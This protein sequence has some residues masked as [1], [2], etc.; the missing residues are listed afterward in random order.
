[1][2]VYEDPQATWEKAFFSR[3]YAYRDFHSAATGAVPATYV[4]GTNTRAISKWNWP[5]AGDIPPG[6][7]PGGRRMPCYA[8][9]VKV[10]CT[11][12]AWIV[13]TSINPDYVR[14]VEMDYTAEQI[15]AYGIP[16]YLVEVPQYL[17]ADE[18]IT[19]YPKYAVSVAWYMATVPGVIYVWCEGNVEGG[20]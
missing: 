18:Q 15:A 14:M 10:L 9:E 2:A 12:D 17:P 16:A 20:E 19:W 7:I 4:F 3:H 5:Q 6:T 11:E 13:L 1:L 8:R